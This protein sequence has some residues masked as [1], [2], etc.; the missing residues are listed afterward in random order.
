MTIFAVNEQGVPHLFFATWPIR[1]YTP[2][3]AY[4]AWHRVFIKVSLWRSIVE[5]IDMWWAYFP[6][7]KHWR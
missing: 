4:I 2:V 6:L 1:D 5:G 7:R 3:G